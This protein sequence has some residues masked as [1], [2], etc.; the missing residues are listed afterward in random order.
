MYPFSIILSNR[1]SEAFRLNAR[2][3]SALKVPFATTRSLKMSANDFI[4]NQILGAAKNIIRPYV[5][6]GVKAVTGLGSQGATQAQQPNHEVQQQPST[7]NTRVVIK[8]ES[9]VEFEKTQFR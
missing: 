1:A 7:S 9:R 4:T 5:A 2:I 6:A 3:S 8:R